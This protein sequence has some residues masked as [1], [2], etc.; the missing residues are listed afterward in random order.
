MYVPYG[1]IDN[2]P[3]LVQIMGCRLTS[4]K[5]LTEYFTGAYIPHSVSVNQMNWIAAESRFDS[6]KNGTVMGH[7]VQQISLQ[8]R[9]NGLDG[10]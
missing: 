7:D 9:H 8:W 6:A 1:L 5:P 3:S 10:I 4:D 2:K